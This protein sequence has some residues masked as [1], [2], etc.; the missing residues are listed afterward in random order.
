MAWTIPKMWKG[1]T[2][3]IIGSGTS[4]LDEFGI[5]IELARQVISGDLPISAYSP[6]FAPIHNK[7]TIAINHMYQLGNWLDVFYFSDNEMWSGEENKKQ[8]LSYKGLRIT[9]N[10]KFRKLHKGI[11]YIERDKKEMGL[12]E[13]KN[14][15][16][17]NRNTGL[18]AIDLAYHFG[19]K[20]V[21]LLGFDMASA[22]IGSHIHGVGT[23]ESKGGSAELSFRS[24]LKAIPHI[25]QDMKDRDIEILNASSIS[26]IPYFP[27][28][29]AKDYF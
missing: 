1:G 6:Y 3:W 14:A 25:I 19:A 11:K 18:S 10:I 16:C 7:H 4:I 17:F 27:K 22:Q 21:I 13:T 28:V 23:K 29:K 2:V 8:I 9:N 26:T 24:H 20:R 12:C 5:P 15:V